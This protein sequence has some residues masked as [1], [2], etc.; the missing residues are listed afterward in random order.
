[1]QLYNSKSSVLCIKKVEDPRSFGVAELNEDGTIKKVVEKPSIPKSNMAL[2]GLYFINETRSL[3]EALEYNIHHNVRTNNEFHLTDA[4]ARMIENGIIFRSYKVEQWFDLGKKEILLETNA[5]LLKKT[6][7]L[8][9]HKG[10]VENSIIIQPVSI[11]EG[12]KIVHSIIG[13]NVTI[14]DHST[15]TCSIIENSIIGS[16]TRLENISLSKSLI[17][18]DANIKGFRQSLNIGDNTEIDLTDR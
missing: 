10:V 13:P 2:V 11:G 12:A 16:Y 17:G 5:T 14:S 8:N 1:S 9:H 4:I 6:E 18:S 7:G 15:I 3:F